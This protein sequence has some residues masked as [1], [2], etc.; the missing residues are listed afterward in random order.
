MMHNKKKNTLHIIDIGTH[1]AQE[2]SLISNK[3]S[4][5][6]M[7]SNFKIS[8]KLFLRTRFWVNF[9]SIRFSSKKINALYNLRIICIEPVL[10]NLFFSRLRIIKPDIL[11][12]GV[13]SSVSS[14]HVPLY[15]GVQRLGNSLFKTKPALNGDQ[16]TTSSYDFDCIF[17]TLLL[18][19]VNP[20]DRVLVRINAE[21]IEKDFIEWLSNQPSVHKKINLISGSLGDIRKCFGQKEF[22]RS[23]LKL[24]S[25]GIP[26]I[27]FTSDPKSWNEALKQIVD[28]LN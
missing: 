18:P 16:I 3:D 1:D 11:V 19:Y 5:K 25:L 12:Q 6:G 8:I 14:G 20:N 27:H 28:T 10:S 21:G 4:L 13:C 23:S 9:K 7:I 24:E 26:F 2:I 22:E 17:K 15:L